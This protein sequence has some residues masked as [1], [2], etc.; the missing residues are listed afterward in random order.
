MNALPTAPGAGERIGPVG[1][2]ERIT[3]L[4]RGCRVDT[5]PQNE[6]RVIV[7]LPVPVPQRTGTG[8]DE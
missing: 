6:T 5:Q 3:V 2:R 8:R 4:G 1:M 7:K